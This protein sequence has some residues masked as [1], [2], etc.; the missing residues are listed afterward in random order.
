MSDETAYDPWADSEVEPPVEDGA[1][2]DVDEFDNILAE[3]DGLEEEESDAAVR[4]PQSGPVYDNP[5]DV[6]LKD[7]MWVPVRL[8]SA[9][10]DEKYA[11]PRLST[12]TCI[13]RK[14]GKTYILHDQVEAAVRAGAEEIIK[15][16]P[17]PHFVCEANHVAPQYG[18]RK[19]PYEIAVP[20]FTIK[21]AL[22]KPRNGRTGYANENGR[23]LRMATASTS[24]GEKVTLGN[25]HEVAG[26]M[27]ETIVMAQVT[28]SQSK[29]AKYRNRVDEKGEQINVLVDPETGSYASVRRLEDGSGYVVEG[30]G[31]IWEGEE[32][33]L[34]LVEGNQYAIR[35]SGDSSAPL[36]ESF[37]P[38]NDFLKSTF[39]PVPDRKVT[40]ARL[41]GT[42][43][44]GEIT[45]DTVGAI[46][47]TKT[48]GVRVDIMLRT[49]DV[50][51]VVWLGTEWS[52]VPSEEPKGSSEAPKREERAEAPQKES[53][54][55]VDKI[56]ESALASL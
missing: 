35:D 16:V 27:G 22:Y 5:Y 15:E 56:S 2:E 4:I 18:Q 29:K 39:L 40:V 17:L 44:E 38:I 3:L 14:D 8:L 21:T 19:Y 30:S 36:K 45:W 41:D 23:S 33:L 10:V 6:G 32:G 12:K 42:E 48:P 25:M 53:A 31:E 1:P 28:I 11:N 13:A 55:G 46:V 47:P 24:P 26:R 50:V 43:A 51:T 9:A 49:G 20:V 54:D 34:V 37:Y 52:E 7:K